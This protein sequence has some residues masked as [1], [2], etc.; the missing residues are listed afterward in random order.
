MTMVAN[1]LSISSSSSSS[2]SFVRSFCLLLLQLFPIDSKNV[3]SLDALNKST[4]NI[5][6]MKNEKKMSKK[7]SFVSSPEEEEEEENKTPDSSSL[8]LYLCDS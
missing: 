2:S 7:K 6:K 3:L 1:A 5:K 8:L 4:L